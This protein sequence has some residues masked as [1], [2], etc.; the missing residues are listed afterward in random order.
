MQQLFQAGGV[1]GGERGERGGVPVWAAGRGR[2]LRQQ[3]DSLQQR[4]D[5]RRG[6][7]QCL[8]LGGD[9][10]VLEGV[11]NLRGGGHLHNPRRPLDRVR[12]PHQPLER[13]LIGRG[14]FEGQHPGGQRLGVQF[15]LGAK[16]LQQRVV[17]RGGH[18]GSRETGN[19]RRETGDGVA[20]GRSA[21]HWSPRCECLPGTRAGQS[22]P[23]ILPS[24][25]VK[26]TGSRRLF[27]TGQWRFQG[28]ELGLL[29]ICRGW[30]SGVPRRGRV[31]NDWD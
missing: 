4:V 2:A 30:C 16:Q 7:L 3:V 9:E 28:S 21:G 25:C 13:R 1:I 12:R 23:P 20:G 19:G 10:T 22:L 17:D 18:G 15:D 24:V 11:G 26:T 29:R 8:P 31:I 14:L 27:L 6:Q 5:V